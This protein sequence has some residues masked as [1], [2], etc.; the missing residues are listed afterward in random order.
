MNFSFLRKVLSSRG[1]PCGCS[2]IITTV[3]RTP[4]VPLPLR[5]LK[6]RRTVVASGGDL[7][8][9]LIAPRIT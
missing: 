3:T 7:T 4:R 6:M 8:S 2:H 9:Q 1:A 5:Q